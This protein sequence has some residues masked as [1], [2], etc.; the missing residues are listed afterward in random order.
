ME[1]GV[2]ALCW[3]SLG[4]GII[5]EYVDLLKHLQEVEAFGATKSRWMTSPIMTVHDM[6]TSGV[7]RQV[8]NLYTCES[9]RY[10]TCTK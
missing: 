6:N 8:F 7:H 10:S 9:L 5:G 3:G 1:L 2:A 4:L